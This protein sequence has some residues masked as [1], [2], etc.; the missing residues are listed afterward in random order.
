M[1][2]RPG[3]SLSRDAARWG[4]R[5][6]L[7]HLV[8]VAGLSLVPSIQRFVAVS[9]GD[10]LPAA[11][12]IGGEV[13]TAATRVLLVFLIF[14]IMWS[15]AGPGAWAR[16]GVFVDRRR[17][18]FLVQFL[19]LGAAFVVFDALP[20]LAIEAWVAPEQRERVT[21]VLIAVKNP[22]V[23]AFTFVWMAGVVRE[24][25]TAE[26]REPTGAGR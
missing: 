7:R 9:M 2:L 8:L 16:F 21:A 5:C 10:E 26:G 14:R 23:I 3:L 6:Y 22:T 20:K 18:A 25:I 19:V 13:L 12:A 1:D 17:T 11:A 15:E 4:A 24:M